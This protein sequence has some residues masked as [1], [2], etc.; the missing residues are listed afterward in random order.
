MHQVSPRI[1][2]ASDLLAILTQLATG[3][4]VFSWTLRTRSH[5]SYSQHASCLVCA[6]RCLVR[7][8]TLPKRWTSAH[9]CSTLRCALHEEALDDPVHYD[10]VV[11]IR[12]A[13]L[14]LAAVAHPHDVL[15]LADGGRFRPSDLQCASAKS[16]D[17]HTAAACADAQC[18]RDLGAAGEFCQAVMPMTPRPRQPS[19][20]RLH[21][22][23]LLCA[24]LLVA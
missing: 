3:E 24:R 12:N 9:T 23:F 20:A 13:K 8:T 7:K 21:F 19:P 5:H 17:Y 4:H 18:N 10:T 15:V 22:S 14:R 6:L 11:P 1:R 16:S 2:R